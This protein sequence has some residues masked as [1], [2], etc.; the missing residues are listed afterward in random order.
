MDYRA[1]CTASM[2]LL[3]FLLRKRHSTID[4]CMNSPV[5]P[6]VR[7][8]PGTKLQSFLTHENFTGRDSLP[9]EAFD[10][11]SFRATISSILG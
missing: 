9:T 1:P 2:E 11:S 6:T 4:V 8:I 10:A 5:L 3:R 7:I